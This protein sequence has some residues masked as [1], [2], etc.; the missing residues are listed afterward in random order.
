MRLMIQIDTDTPA[1][2]DSAESRNREIA[3]V[4]HKL[5]VEI[6]EGCDLHRD[7]VDSTYNSAGA[8]WIA[9]ANPGKRATAG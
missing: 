9:I 6:V 4:L 7:L 8:V 1:F 5:A 3:H 2:G